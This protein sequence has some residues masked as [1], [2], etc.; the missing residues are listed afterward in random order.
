M[1][2]CLCS[3][4]RWSIDC[5]NDTDEWSTCMLQRGI[6]ITRYIY[7]KI[8]TTS[9]PQFMVEACSL[10]DMR[11]VLTLRHKQI[12][13]SIRTTLPNAFPRIKS[14][15]FWFKSTHDDVIERKHFSRYW[16]FVRE[17]GATAG[18]RPVTRSFHFFF[19]LHRN[20]RLS[21]QSRR[22]CR[23][24]YTVDLSPRD[25]QRLYNPVKI[26]LGN[27]KVCGYYEDRVTTSH[28]SQSRIVWFKW[29][30]PW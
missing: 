12:C 23:K 14:F 24:I 3:Q 10:F 11:C 1:S 13:N 9:P 28:S 21:K 4:Y 6:V 17:P 16:P 25:H 29:T 2:P 22:T 30:S 18:Q 19:N 7:L 5:C 8:F 15:I 26:N 20:K 27:S